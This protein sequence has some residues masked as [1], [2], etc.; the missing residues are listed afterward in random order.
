[1]PE[2]NRNQSERSYNFET[3]DIQLHHL[4]PTGNPDN[5]S[6]VENSL[7]NKKKISQNVTSDIILRIIDRLKGI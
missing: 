7:N 6:S 1:M 2:S 3:L 4:V 5:Q